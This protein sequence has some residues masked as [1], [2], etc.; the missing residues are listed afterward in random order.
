M[1]QV[2]AVSYKPSSWYKSESSTA[3]LFCFLFLPATHSTH[4]AQD[5][6]IISIVNTASMSSFPFHMNHLYP[7]LIVQHFDCSLFLVLH[8]LN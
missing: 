8:F 6:K 7:L 2:T 3:H 1:L 4:S 5:A